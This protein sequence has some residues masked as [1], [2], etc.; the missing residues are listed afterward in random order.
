MNDDTAGGAPQAAEDPREVARQR[1]STLR[2]R[3]ADGPGSTRQMLLDWAK[4]QP[5]LWSR[6]QAAEACGLLPTGITL[7]LDKLRREGRIISERQTERRGGGRGMRTTRG[8]LYLFRLATTVAEG[9]QARSNHSLT[10]ELDEVLDRAARLTAE[11][12]RREEALLV[13]GG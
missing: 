12:R 1:N 13:E 7:Q 2:L 4:K 5:G 6:E 8:P 3:P 11:L 9:L 10:V